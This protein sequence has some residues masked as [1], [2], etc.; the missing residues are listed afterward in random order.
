[1]CATVRFVVLMARACRSLQLKRVCSRVGAIHPVCGVGFK[2]QQ[3]VAWRSSQ[4]CVCN[5]ARS[6]QGVHEGSSY[7]QRS[8]AGWGMAG[9]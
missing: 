7:G 8:R 5:A 9:A 3:V 2:L 4:I 6:K 1:M